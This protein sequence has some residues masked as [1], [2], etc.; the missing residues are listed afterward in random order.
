[1][2]QSEDYLAQENTFT[3]KNSPLKMQGVQR[4]YVWQEYLFLLQSQDVSLAQQASGQQVSGHKVST[5]GQ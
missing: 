3:K 5:A 4:G 1:M 2:S